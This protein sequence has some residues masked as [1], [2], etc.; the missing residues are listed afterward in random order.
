M[1]PARVKTVLMGSDSIALL[2]FEALRMHPRIEVVGVFT[3]PDRPSGRGQQLHV[4]P[5]KAWALEHGLTVLQPERVRESEVA[6]IKKSGA[7]VAFVK[8]YGQ[9]LRQE[10]LDLFD[11]GVWNFHVSILPSYRGSSPM[12]G[13]IASGDESSGVSLMR[14]VL[15]MDAGAVLSIERVNLAS[16]ETQNTLDVKLA[17]CSKR[18]VDK[19]ITAILDGTAV[20]VEQNESVAT[21]VRKLNKTDAALDWNTPAIELER[22]I[23]ALTPWPGSVLEYGNHILKIGLP[24]RVDLLMHDAPGK[25]LG[26]RE[27]FLWVATKVGALGIGA[28]QRPGGKMLA[29]EAF[30]RGYYLT[31]GSILVSHTMMP[32]VLDAPML[33]NS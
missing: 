22:R 10:T 2:A 15:K 7:D 27:G 3:Q 33:K 1:L 21:Y 30:V 9:L 4:G 23:R 12:V 5:I 24:L 17:G 31:K 25:L 32:L 29:V 20:C 8:G 13:A 11:L 6:W 18:L 14:L 16:D 28:L 26:V 19:H